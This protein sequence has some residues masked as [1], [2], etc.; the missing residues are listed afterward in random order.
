MRRII[1]IGMMLA[2]SACIT[3]PTPAPTATVVA[4]YILSAEDNPYAPK[5]GD[6]SLRVAGVTITSINLIERFDL[7]PVRAEVDFYGSLP[8]VCN[9]LRIKVN[10]PNEK[11][12]VFIDVYS[13]VNPNIRCDNV[14]QQFEAS[15][16]L[17]VY[18]SGR[19]T[20]WVNG[21]LIGDFVSY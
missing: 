13:L 8:S 17:G 20:V 19:F 12:Q 14:F 11:A 15:V 7:N 21:G 10:P 3:I 2:L 9:E 5:P 1:V 18:S 16:V 6:T 4:P